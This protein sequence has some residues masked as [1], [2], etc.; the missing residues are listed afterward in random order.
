LYDWANYVLHRV[1]CPL[2]LTKYEQLAFPEDGI[3]LGTG[4]F[5]FEGRVMTHNTV[6][7][8]IVNSIRKPVLPGRG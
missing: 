6:D 3:T 4:F 7:Q 5:E 1:P 2:H 8:W